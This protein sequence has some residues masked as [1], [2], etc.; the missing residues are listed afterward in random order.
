MKNK[1]IWW[2]ML[3]VGVLPF[4]IPFLGFAYEMINSSSW[5]L[6]DYL[7]LYSFLYWPTYIL[8]IIMIII[9]VYK[10]NNF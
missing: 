9:S 4:I 1:K 5:S 6:F 3:V 2:I 7:V 8:G 10:L